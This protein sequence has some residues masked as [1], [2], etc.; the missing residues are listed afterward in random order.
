MIWVI[1]SI[2]LLLLILFVFFYPFKITLYN[3]S[4]YLHIRI[5]NII[6]LKLNLYALLEES[7]IDELKKQSKSIKILKKLKLKQLDI[8]LRGF[9][10]NYQING[11]YYGI[12]LGILPSINKLLERNNITFNYLVDYTGELYVKFKSIVRGNF[13]NILKV[14]YGI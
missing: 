9:N 8:Y 7:N 3:D 1:I 4:K 6:T 10:Y 5:S 14:F 2:I 13:S 11:I 12:L